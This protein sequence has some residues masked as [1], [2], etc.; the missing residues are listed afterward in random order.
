MFVLGFDLPMMLSD[1]I[2]QRLIWR[3]CQAL[4]KLDAEMRNSL[5]R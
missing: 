1:S 5:K 3:V 4:Y 2:G